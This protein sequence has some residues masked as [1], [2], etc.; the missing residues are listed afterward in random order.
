MV[1]CVFTWVPIGA[2][3]HDRW[4][5]YRHSARGPRCGRALATVVARGEAGF[6]CRRSFV[7][8]CV[9]ACLLVRAALGVA[10]LVSQERSPL[11]RCAPLQLRTRSVQGARSKSACRRVFRARVVPSVQHSVRRFPLQHSP[12]FRQAI[13]PYTPARGDG[14]VDNDSMCAVGLDGTAGAHYLPDTKKMAQKSRNI[15]ALSDGRP[16]GRRTTQ[17][18]TLSQPAGN[19]GPK[20]ARRGQSR[21][22]AASSQD[23]SCQDP[24]SF[25]ERAGRRADQSPAWGSQGP[26]PHGSLPHRVC[27]HAPG[28][29]AGIAGLSPDGEELPSGPEV[30]SSGTVPGGRPRHR[31]TQGRWV[32]NVTKSGEGGRDCRR[33]SCASAAW[34]LTGPGVARR[35]GGHGSGASARFDV[36]GGGHG[37]SA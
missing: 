14:D 20:R 17:R 25:Q 28:T 9:G 11:Q 32:L 10:V 35:G 33:E 16:Q 15:A 18:R 3:P 27:G 1:V 36:A 2:R 21:W 26:C 24:R 19:A 22:S 34:A 30:K 4:A 23:G 37:R 13:T 7:D 12:P 5:S 31:S 8:N 6:L 29:P